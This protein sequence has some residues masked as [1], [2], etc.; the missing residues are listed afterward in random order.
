MIIPVIHP[1]EEIKFPKVEKIGLKNAIPV[2]GFNGATNDI[3]R[4]DLVFDSGRWTEPDKLI[5]ES[6]A[7]LFKSGTS[8]L[9]SFA[10][11][12]QID[13]YGSTIKAN[14]GYNTMTVSV[15]CMHRYLEATL[16]LLMTCLNDIVFP[17][18]EIAIMK[19]NAIAKL[20]VN[21]EK[22]DFLAN[23][24]FK[25]II[26]GGTH[27]FGYAV[28]EETIQNIQQALLLQLYNNDIQPNN[29]T[30]FIAGKY[31]ENEL[32]LIDTYL[33][34]WQKG[35]NQ[36]QEKK[37]YTAV[38]S[39]QKI[40]HI[41]KE[42]SVQASIVIGKEFFNRSHED[43]ASFVLLNTIFGGYFGSR[44]MSNIREEKGLTYGIYSGLSTLK[45]TGIYAIQT[46]TNL[47]NLDTCL[48]EIYTEIERLQNELIPE[49]EITL[50]RNYLLGK[51]LGRT[52]GAFSQLETFK[53]YFIEGID[54]NMFEEFVQRIQQTDAVSLQ[55]LAQQHLQKES[56]FEVVVG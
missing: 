1:I 7:K 22:N 30:I 52:D 36:P 45:T 47:E 23:V 2:F 11:N 8:T 37:T 12:E 46:D 32:K 38:S 27:P 29:C 33:G 53:S 19:K 31:G 56:L 44:L 21:Q 16:Q 51:F 6:V 15:Y 17:E 24:A 49:N 14:S 34:N 43:Y 50:A 3:L 25:E 18:N 35:N 10:L 9:N 28:S 5:S 4:I 13:F 41:K 48:H 42:K 26:F 54:I 20:K 39:T 40:S 55:Q